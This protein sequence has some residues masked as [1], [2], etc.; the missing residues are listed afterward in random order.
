M[1][2]K[3]VLTSESPRGKK[4]CYVVFRITE[5][6]SQALNILKRGG[7]IDGRSDSQYAR[8]I[9]L[10]F[11]AGNLAYNTAKRDSMNTGNQG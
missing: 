11:L 6:E 5:A 7:P 9:I 8:K 3:T 10:D 1:K 4:T 2:N